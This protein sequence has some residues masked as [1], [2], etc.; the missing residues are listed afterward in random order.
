MRIATVVLVAIL[1]CG[2]AVFLSP[3]G[4]W[5]PGATR[6]D[7]YKASVCTDLKNLA[8]YQEQY[9]NAHGHYTSSFD[10]LEFTPNSREIIAFSTVTDTAW[11]AIGV[12]QA[13]TGW[14]SIFVGDVESPMLRATEGTCACSWADGG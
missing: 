12:H 9:F 4:R 10:S 6:T 11:S 14:C 3:L 1:V 5:R 7:A 13:L 8:F 2:A